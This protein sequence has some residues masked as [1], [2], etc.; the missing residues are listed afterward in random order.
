MEFV[1]CLRY[2]IVR[3]FGRKETF[4]TYLPKTP[5][6][7]LS[8]ISEK[9]FP[10]DKMFIGRVEIGNEIFKVYLKAQL[11]TNELVFGSFIGVDQELIFLSR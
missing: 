3:R 8:I 5:D 1:L 9:Y 10:R 7:I 2:N 11:L 6:I 4:T